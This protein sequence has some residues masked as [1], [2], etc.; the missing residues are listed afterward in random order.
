[1]IQA[2][3]S[4]TRVNLLGAERPHLGV[5]MAR[6]IVLE[7]NHSKSYKT[8]A[9]AHKAMEKYPDEIRYFILPLSNGRFTPVVLGAENMFMV[10][11]GFTVTG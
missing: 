5:N 1:M 10:H 3:T 6:E 8:K 7:N 2:P 11:N 9:N 4:L